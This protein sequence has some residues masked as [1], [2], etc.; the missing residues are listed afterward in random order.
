MKYVQD[1][2]AA[3]KEIF[4][5]M[6]MLEVSAGESFS[7]TNSKLED[8]VSGIVG[9]AG[10]I[11]GMLAIHLPK[12]TAL[13]VTTA[14]LGMDVE[15][16]DEDVCDAIGELANMLGGSLKAAIDP[17]GSKVQLSMPSAIHGQEYTIDCLADAEL[18]TVP[19]TF[20]NHTFMVELQISQS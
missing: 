19:F 13:A 16:V 12:K 5:T 9:L 3:T 11:K 1:I 20:D 10:D 15:D 2:A 6:I 17:G 18:I 7:R 4:S 8:S 14:F